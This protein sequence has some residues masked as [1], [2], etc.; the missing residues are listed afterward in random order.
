LVQAEQ[1]ESD[2]LVERLFALDWAWRE[3]PEDRRLRLDARLWGE[4]SPRLA[5][6]ND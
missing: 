1:E 2:E 5:D 4:V 6:E 3:L